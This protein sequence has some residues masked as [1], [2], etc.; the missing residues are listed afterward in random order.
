[1]TYANRKPDVERAIW[2]SRQ[3]RAA[4]SARRRRCALLGGLLAVAL[5]G[6]GTFSIGALTGNEMIEAAAAQAKSLADLLDQ[7]S[8]GLRSQ[9]QL[10]KTK[11]AKALSRMRLAAK[12]KIHQALEPK[13]AMV[14][15]AKLLDLPPSPLVAEAPPSLTPLDVAPPSVQTIVIPPGAN[16]PP[17]GSPPGSPPPGSMPPGTTPPGSPTNIIVPVPSAVPEPASWAMMLIGFAFVG[18]RVR[19][20]RQPDL[21]RA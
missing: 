10:M 21:K 19:A 9:G 6:A 5:A 12:P 18:W 1:M 3:S 13:I 17:G 8:P 20:S 11:H 14:D 7:R 4:L 2:R 16:I 15:L